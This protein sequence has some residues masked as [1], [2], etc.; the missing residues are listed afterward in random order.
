MLHLLVL[1]I[2]KIEINMD[3]FALIACAYGL[4]G[5]ISPSI[6]TFFGQVLRAKNSIL[7]Y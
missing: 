6:V 4:D 2:I 5:N 3:L 7:L 1:K